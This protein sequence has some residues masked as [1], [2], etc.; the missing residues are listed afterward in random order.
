MKVSIIFL[1]YNHA[2]FVGDALRSALS[3]DYPEYELIVHDDG[4]TDG[5]RQIIESIL[6]KEVPRHVR[7]VIAGDGINHGL[8]EAFN[9]AMSASTGEILIHFSGDDISYS[10]RLSRSV[11][12]FKK[13]PD[14]M[15]V[16]SEAHRIDNNRNFLTYTN[17]A[18][19]DEMYSYVTEPKHIYAHSPIL[20]AAAAYRA[21]VI[22]NFN[23][24]IPG[25]CHAEDNVY[26]VRAL[27]LGKIYYIADSLLCY[28]LHLDNISENEW[29]WR[30]GITDSLKASHLEFVRKHSL[31]FLQWEI[32]IKH[33]RQKGYIDE[34]R[35]AQ[36]LKTAKLDAMRWALIFNALSV[37]PWSAWFPLAL[38]SI[39]CGGL[40]EFTNKLKLRLSERR[41]L[42]YWNTH[43]K[44]MAGR[45]TSS[46]GPFLTFPFIEWIL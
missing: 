16:V 18:P 14:V 36:A 1:S 29:K 37:E 3:Q 10:H 32:D 11:E 27:L 30:L 12:V 13:Q 39:K 15:L 6:A 9:R 45:L 35:F 34:S 8:I 44:Y 41:R 19:K 38:E 17:Y 20:G 25:F 24:I 43:A 2:G 23:P 7:V 46:I 26:W 21:C 4:S 22:K 5:T 33:A 28:R 40:R 31:N 42:R